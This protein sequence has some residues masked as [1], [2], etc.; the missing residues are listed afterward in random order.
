VKQLLIFYLKGTGLVVFDAALLFES[1]WDKLVSSVVL[2]Y[3][4]PD[5]QLSRLMKRDGSLEEDAAKR[6]ASQMPQSEKASRATVVV[7]NSNDKEETLRQLDSAIRR[8][9]PSKLATLLWLIG[10]LAAI[11]SVVGFA[12]WTLLGFFQN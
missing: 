12:G 4:E 8:L 7:D 5:I 9:T 3:C 1:K 6:I 11:G 2:V 10:P